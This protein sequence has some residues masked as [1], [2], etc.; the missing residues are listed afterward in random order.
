MYYSNEFDSFK[1]EKIS[2]NHDSHIKQRNWNTAF[3]L[4]AVDNLK[5]SEYMVSLAKEN[6]RGTLSYDDVETQIASYYSKHPKGT[7]D[8]S[9]KEADEVSLRIVRLLN[10]NSFNFSF[11]T[12]KQFHKYLFSG[13]DLGIN[14]RYNGNFRD[15]NISKKEPVLNGKSVIYTD[16]KMIEDTLQYDFDEEK[17]QKYLKMNTRQQ[18]E[19]IAEFTSRIWQIHPFA[20][21]NTRTTAVFIQ[22]I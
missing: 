2:E 18:I 19:R 1:Y 6:V 13:V 12:L 17:A 8:R 9:E 14:G 22:N 15:Y 16:F 7:I 4:Q 11:L 10:D 20:E 21:G 3:G 5:P